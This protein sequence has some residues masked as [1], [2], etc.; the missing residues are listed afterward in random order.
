MLL[1][2]FHM[3]GS[4]SIRLSSIAFALCSLFAPAAAFAQ[5]AIWR[6]GGSDDTYTNPTNWQGGLAPD[7]SG[8]YTIKLSFSSDVISVNTTANVAGV[9]Y[10][11][12]VGFNNAQFA[13]S[14]SVTIGAGGISP[15][16]G[17]GATLDFNVPI[18]LSA[19]QTW[20]AGTGSDYGFISSNTGIGEAGGPATLT[21]GNGQVYMYGTNTFSGGLV[22][23]STGAL[24]AGTNSAAGTGTLTLQDGAMLEAA[25][26]GITIANP[27]ALGNNVVLGL[28]DP[29]ESLN[30]SG[31]V[32]AA[33]ASTTVD[34][35]ASSSVTISGTLT[36]PAGANYD[37]FGL[38]G[39]VALGDGGSQLIFSGAV[40]QVNSITADTSALILAPTTPNPMNSYTGLAGGF[41]VT[42]QGYLGLDGTFTAAGG[43]AN[44]LATFGPG[45]A[46]S[47]DGTIGFDNVENPGT[48]NIF[49][50][51][52]NLTG[53]LHD[54]N[55]LGLGSATQAV[56]TGNI[57]P[58]SDNW[59]V[60][61]GGGGTLTVTSNLLDNS[62]TALAMSRAPSPL[63]L[64]IQGANDYTGGVVSQGGVL[65]FDST[66]LPAPAAISLQG[67]YV[68]YTEVPGL[69]SASFISLFNASGAAQGVIGFDQHTPDLASPRLIGDTI[70]LSAFNVDSSVFLGTSTAAEFTVLASIT[71]ANDNY[72]FTGVKGGEL[73]VDTFLADGGSP[74]SLTLG[75]VDPIEGNGS[76]SR[77]NLTGINTF[78]GG[79]TINSG[80]VFVSSSAAFG[81]PTGTI[82]VPDSVA[83]PAPYL[84]S[85]G[86]LP[87][88]VANP[89]ALGSMGGGTSQGLTVGNASPATGD[90]LVLGGVISDFGVS[91][92]GL[93]GIS[94]P[95]TLAGANTYSGGTIITGN[96]NAEVLVTNSM[97]FGAPTGPITVQDDGVIAP[98][99]VDVTLPN[100][101][102]LDN[103]PL[104][105]GASL[106]PFVLTLNGI[107]S[108][109]GSLT[110]DSG[111]TL[112]GV[113]TYSGPT[114][115]NDANVIIGNAAAF[116][117]G[118]VTLND[119]SLSFTFSNPMILDLSGADINSA[120]NLTP[121]Q[122]LT[123]Q[124]DSGGG[125][126]A[127]AINGDGTDSVVIAGGGVQQLSGN[128][129]YGGGTDVAGGT[130][131]VSSPTAIGTGTVAVSSG[132]DLGVA[133]GTTLTLP[134]SLSGNATLSGS[135]A[136]SPVAP[137]TFSGGN[138]VMPGFATNG[139]YVGTLSFGNSVVFGPSGVYQFN[140]ATASGAAGV[141]YSTIDIGGS[142]TISATSGSPFVIAMNSI[143]PGAGPGTAVFSST[144]PYSWTILTANTGIFGFN[145]TLFTVNTANFQN[146][147]GGGSLIVGQSGDVLTLDFTPV[148]EPSTWMLMLTGVAGV[149][150]LRRRRK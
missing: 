56:L 81:A 118:S 93:L 114:I 3:R 136:F 22:V 133:S 33:N 148:P 89:I 92:L 120:V 97:S 145:P 67:G 87:V 50:D 59:Y 27:V 69:S 64:I 39:P 132:A 12:A 66:I 5:T 94:G 13:G 84:A 9:Q 25:S 122:T 141:D 51:N 38:G 104:T 20:T 140:L 6:G 98:L 79:T 139:Q 65:I 63:T 75:L 74:Y 57:S 116:G 54:S 143:T 77:V 124:T 60:F 32:T 131:I 129:T 62:G 11:G 43:V 121:G 36:G 138:T 78:T 58:T 134:I 1:G 34:V 14:G 8:A 40:S 115:V 49:S 18:I 53:F 127:G 100:P 126:Y 90:M 37:I 130:L 21:I 68:G 117:A 35:A 109:N 24:Y 123:L 10:L 106:N 135:G 4:S 72:Q 102:S 142:L 45:L 29:G 119:S 128:S 85:Y 125:S 103:S 95:V 61:G 30:L 112:N 80:A 19:S 144:Q 147:L 28:T 82:S 105:L 107:I 150:F 137:I 47:I 73:T 42:N 149:G 7:N 83:I 70:N 31:T 55:F 110:I 113:N 111:V 86:G 52:I 88:A 99:G 16:G 71:P 44:F 17:A 108:G 46:S 23:S 76:I 41:M 48:P 2:R 101:I 91:N 15:G 96:G 146:S 26:S